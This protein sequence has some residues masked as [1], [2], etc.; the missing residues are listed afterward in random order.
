MAWGEHGSSCTACPSFSPFWLLTFCSDTSPSSPNLAGPRAT[1]VASAWKSGAG[2]RAASRAGAEQPK[3]NNKR[4][5]QEGEDGGKV[6]EGDWQQGSGIGTGKQGVGCQWQ[7][8]EAR[9]THRGTGGIEQ[10]LGGTSGRDQVQA[11]RSRWQGTFGW[12]QVA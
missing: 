10:T 6:Q 2:A 1:T 9:H 8:V 12:G 7:G 5:A 3:G 11:Q 4:E